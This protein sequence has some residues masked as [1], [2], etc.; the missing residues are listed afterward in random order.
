M[1]RPKLMKK[2]IQQTEKQ[3]R[4][5][6]LALHVAAHPKMV[7]TVIEYLKLR[8]KPKEPAKYIEDIDL[9]YKDGQRAAIHQFSILTHLVKK[10]KGGA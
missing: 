3:L 7:E 5:N 2:Q 10:P 8:F 6:E 4:Q 9:S 1:S